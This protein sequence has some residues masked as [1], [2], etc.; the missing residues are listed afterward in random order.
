MKNIVK[1]LLAL[2]AGLVIVASCAQEEA[3][4]LGSSVSAT[5]AELVVSDTGSSIIGT[6]DVKAD[7]IW[8]AT[9]SNDEWFEYAPASGE[10]DGKITVS[11]KENVDENN[12]VAGPRSGSIT[13]ICG[14]SMFVVTVKQAGEPGLD[15]SRT[16]KKVSKAEEIEAGK[17]YLF[18]AN[19]GSALVAGKPFAA[20]SETYYSYI[21]GDDVTAEDDI[22][23]RPNANNAY[24]LVA[25]GE[26][27]AI[28]Q[29]NGR[30]LFQASAYNNFYSTDNLEKAD[31]W[32]ITLNEDGTA[33]I[34][35]QTVAGKYFQYSIGYSSYGS[36]G[37]AQDGA[38]LPSLYKDSAAPSDEVLTVAE[39]TIVKG[40]ETVAKIAVK[41]NKTWKVRN[42]DEWIKS[43][44][45]EGS[46]DGTIEITF[47]AN[48]S[49]ETTRK[50]KFQ[51]IGETTNFWITL[52]QDHLY[53]VID[54]S[55]AEFKE[56]E[57]GDQLYRLTGKIKGIVNSTYGN[58]YLQDG[59]GYVYVYTLFENADKVAKSFANLGVREGD[60]VTV[61]GP[62]DE[63][64]T[65]KV[66]DQ[67]I[68]MKNAYCEKT[69][70][71]QDVT[72]S[73]IIAAPVASTYL[74]SKYYRV[75]GLVKSVVNDTYGNFYLQEEKSDKY[76][77][78]YGLTDA[79]VKS[80]N[81]SY[82]SLG[83]A[84]G[85]RVT[86]VGQRGQYPGAK[87]EDQK[88]QVSNA[89]YISHETPAPTLDICEQIFVDAGYKME[90]YTRVEISWTHNGYYNSTGGSSITTTADNSTQFAATQ[91]FHRSKLPVGTVLVIQGSTSS[92]ADG[93]MYRPEGWK[94]NLNTKTASGNRP[95]NV[96]GKSKPI[97]VI[98]DAWWDKYNPCESGNASTVYF[99]YR[100]F[101]V[102]RA[103]NPKLDA[104]QQEE[105]EHVFGIFIPKPLAS[106]DDILKANNYD[107][108]NYTKLTFTYTKDAFYNSTS[109]TNSNLVTTGNNVVQFVATSIVEKAKIPNGSLIVVNYGYQYRPEG[110]Q[111]LGSKN[112]AARP[113]N[114]GNNVVVVDDAWW[115]NFNYRAF[116]LA[117]F[118][119]PNMTTDAERDAVIA[120]FAVYVPKN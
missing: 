17:G 24:T 94:D 10:G 53:A 103:G 22:I 39:S 56:K 7:G 30:Y 27:Y 41:S 58:I 105:L 1:S 42:H 12:E 101:N 54:C 92:V 113:G 81:K 111:T 29:S 99:T 120:A 83:I 18:V 119:N 95:K 87:V 91:T 64:P 4:P 2:A 66:E 51:I 28:Q 100:A 59:T 6:I 48:E 110:W 96:T 38:V 70:K 86:L 34:E 84:V 57:V 68:Q 49:Y 75:T 116:N 78:V 40:T 46:G 112:T 15:A 9:S 25:K 108:A 114:V 85:D 5:P 55:V 93:W 109:D 62:R 107:P 102:A 44:T 71:S 32:K 13:L 16:Y 115:G 97:T 26:G 37:S 72:V 98:N 118:G 73:E 80:N 11:L 65:A 79:P 50:A 8:I 82:K 90:D 61:V 35:N 76:I 23:V 21:Y 117:K 67:K 20:T 33:K 52:T 63:F 45:K 43:F 106:T 19:T 60:I 104:T 88:E 74:E 36:Y 47:D 14:Q 69:V 31:V 3:E 77:Y 89:Y